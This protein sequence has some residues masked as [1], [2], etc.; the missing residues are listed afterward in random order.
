MY[1]LPRITQVTKENQP[2]STGSSTRR[3]AVTHVGIEEENPT[4][5][6]HFAT[7]Q[8]LTTSSSNYIP[9]IIKSKVHAPGSPS[10]SEADTAAETDEKIRLSQPFPKRQ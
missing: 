6:I 9:I 7:Q 1:T 8:K 2:Y 4:Y 5:G 3:W 10:A